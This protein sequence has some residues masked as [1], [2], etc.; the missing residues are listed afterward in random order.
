MAK[1]KRHIDQ[2]KDIFGKAPQLGVEGFYDNPVDLWEN[3][4]EYFVQCDARQCKPT[5]AGLTAYLGYS[6]PEKL[7]SLKDKPHFGYVIDKL[8]LMLKITLEEIVDDKNF[9]TQGVMFRMKQ[10]GYKDTV[11]S[12]SKVIK[13]FN[14]SDAVGFDDNEEDYED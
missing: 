9:S 1:F 8:Y 6:H 3:G 14:I 12:E 4:Y 13:E 10:L 7:Y 2:F 11:H 5:L